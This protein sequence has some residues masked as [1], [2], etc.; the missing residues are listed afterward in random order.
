MLFSFKRPAAA[1][2][3]RATGFIFA[4]SLLLAAS[5]LAA[6]RIPFKATAA[7]QAAAK[8]AVI[9]RTDL[10][11]PWTGG[12]IKPQFDSDTGC[13]DWKP[14]QSDL[15]ITGAAAATYT[16]PG[17]QITSE[18]DMLQSTKMVVLDWQRTAT[19][20]RAFGCMQKKLVKAI[21]SPQ[22]TLVSFSKLPFPRLTAQTMA[23]RALID[24]KTNGTTQRVVYGFIGIG[25]GRQE[26]SLQTTVSYANRAQGKAIEVG[27]AR[28][29]VA[30][31][32][33]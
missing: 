5:A 10:T 13:P 28:I 32:S 19:N 24:V 15:L 6:E 18:V 8:A 11:G 25:K 30:R 21:N 27:L 31:L 23:F 16:T 20:P 9:Q 22:R 3:A 1:R 33:N 7:D 2:A 12:A 4:S 17:L 29:V 26:V 14:K